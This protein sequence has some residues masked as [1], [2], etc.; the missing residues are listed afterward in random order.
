MKITVK[1]KFCSKCYQRIGFGLP[2]LVNSNLKLTK[3]IVAILIA[4][5]E[6][7]ALS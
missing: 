2:H 6:G 3:N 5:N 4:A 7:V 1:I